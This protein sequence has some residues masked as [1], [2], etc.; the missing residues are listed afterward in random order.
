MKGHGGLAHALVEDVLVQDRSLDVVIEE[1]RFPEPWDIADLIRLVL[2][3]AFEDHALYAVLPNCGRSMSL[4]NENSG[5]IAGH[6]NLDIVTQI[7]PSRQ[8]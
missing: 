1:K 7:H 3:F 6:F 5:C 8:T 2:S 4:V